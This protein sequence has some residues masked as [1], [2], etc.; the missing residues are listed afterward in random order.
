MN[1]CTSVNNY[2]NNSISHPRKDAINQLVR[3]IACVLLFSSFLLPLF[4]TS[5]HGEG[6]ITSGTKGP[7]PPDDLLAT[8]GRFVKA[9]QIGDS[10]TIKS[11][12]LPSTAEVSTVSRDSKTREY[13]TDINLPFLRDG[14]NPAIF[15]VSSS[16]T[17]QFSLRTA[18]SFIAFAKLD[19]VGWRIY[20]YHDKPI[21]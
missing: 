14:F 21:E 16:G 15:V 11:L 1:K 10:D 8:Y 20:C 5:A 13:G 19:S 18:S 17:S 9:A 6:Y 4:S 3:F 2:A 12:L 7:K